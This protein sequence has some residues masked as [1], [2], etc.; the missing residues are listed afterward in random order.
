MWFGV[1]G[2]IARYCKFGDLDEDGEVRP[3][4]FMLKAKDDNN[5]LSV[6]WLEFLN[7]SSRE[8]EIIE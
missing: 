7:C 6:D 4:A 1:A 2:H 5:E 3:S 8:D